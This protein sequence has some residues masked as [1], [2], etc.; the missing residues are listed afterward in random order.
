M[1]G[2]GWFLG[3]SFYSK[4]NPNLKRATNTKEPLFLHKNMLLNIKTGGGGFLKYLF[5]FVPA[6]V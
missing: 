3:F 1:L 4:K 5:T 6:N 2:M